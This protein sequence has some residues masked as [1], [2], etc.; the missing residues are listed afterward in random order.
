MFKLTIKSVK[1]GEVK[2]L[3]FKTAELAILYRDYHL[4]FG[5]FN[6]IVKWVEEKDLKDEDK[7]FIIDEKMEFINN[8][9]VKL[10]RLTEGLELKI[11]ETGIDTIVQFWKEFRKKRNLILSMTDWT[12]LPDSELSVD[13]RKEYR[14]YRSYLRTLPSLHNDDSII[15]AKVYSLEE[16]KKGKR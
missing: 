13:E 11:Q 15:N 9:P 7:P 8:S 1:T 10:Y 4:A 2:H 14:S 16:W 12:Q 5:N 3:E 6:K